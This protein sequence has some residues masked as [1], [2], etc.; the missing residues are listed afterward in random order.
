MEST[1]RNSFIQ[2]PPCMYF[3]HR[4]HRKTNRMR[5]AKYSRYQSLG[6][7]IIKAVSNITTINVVPLIMVL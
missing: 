6:P 1:G 5:E 3:V 4:K 7:Y 2:S